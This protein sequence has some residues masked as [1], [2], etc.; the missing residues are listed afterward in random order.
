VPIIDWSKVSVAAVNFTRSYVLYYYD[1][2]DGSWVKAKPVYHNDTRTYDI[3]Q[4]ADN[5]LIEKLPPG[6]LSRYY[7]KLVYNDTNE[8]LK[9]WLWNDNGTLKIITGDVTW[10]LTP[11][12]LQKILKQIQLQGIFDKWAEQWSDIAAKLGLLWLGK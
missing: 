12:E 3:V 10:S 1:K 9:G 11:Q 8:T 7:Y 4:Y 5:S 6:N 2:Q